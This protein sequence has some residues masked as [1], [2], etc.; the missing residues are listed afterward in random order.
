MRLQR[1]IKLNFFLSIYLNNII[2]FIPCIH[3]E[4]V[5]TNVYTINSYTLYVF[6]P[7]SSIYLIF[8]CLQRI[9]TSTSRFIVEYNIWF[10]SIII[11][12]PIT[13]RPA[14][15]IIDILFFLSISQNKIFCVYISHAKLFDILI[16]R[17]DR[18]LHRTIVYCYYYLFFRYA[19][20]LDYLDR[21][22]EESSLES[23]TTAYKTFGI[24]F[25][26]DGS[27]YCLEW[28]PG[29]K[30]LYLAGDFSECLFIYLKIYSY[31]RG[32]RMPD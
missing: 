1:H 7:M 6:V 27:V 17:F 25:N 28:A 14:I 19:A 3:V 30:Q 15:K 20:F 12:Y 5:F 23:F 31:L 8:Y 21:V 10:W 26:T 13:L 16:T 29:A 24:H 9:R 32:A 22:K 11:F 2:S 18:L 4:N